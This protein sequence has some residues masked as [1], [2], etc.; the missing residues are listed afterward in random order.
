M[1]RRPAGA[2]LFCALWLGPL[3]VGAQGQSGWARSPFQ[4]RG[5]KKAGPWGM[6]SHCS[7]SKPP[8]PPH[9]RGLLPSRAE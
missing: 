4:G 9:A 7:W 6:L 5:G 1:T 3:N 2:G 8:R